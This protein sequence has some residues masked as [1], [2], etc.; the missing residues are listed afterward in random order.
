MADLRTPQQRKLKRVC[1]N[2]VT[3]VMTADLLGTSVEPLHVKVIQL[4]CMVIDNSVFPQEA[5]ISSQNAERWLGLVL[6]SEVFIGG[7]HPTPKFHAP[8][9]S[10][11]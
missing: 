6:L 9:Y 2:S 3:D 11:T 8:F 10:F 4:A 7:A 5:C 1:P